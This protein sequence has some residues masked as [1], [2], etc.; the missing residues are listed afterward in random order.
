MDAF[1]RDNNATDDDI[2][3]LIDIHSG[4][5]QIYAATAEAFIPQM[6][7]LDFVAGLSFTKGCYPGQ[8][9]VARLRYLGKVKQRMIAA[10]V[11]INAAQPGDPIY[12]AGN[13][14]KVGTIVDAVQTD[15]Q[16]FTISTT[17][18]AGVS[19]ALQTSDGS[20]L[21]LISLPYSTAES[22]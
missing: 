3:R 20:K 16:E 17:A 4:I 5:P 11:A 10:T 6:I 9:I 22:P 12:T 7:N 8:E 19:E 18:P 15:K 13:E 1:A 14:Q 21:N 2:W